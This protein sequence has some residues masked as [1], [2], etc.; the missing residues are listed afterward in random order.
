MQQRHGT[1]VPTPTVSSQSSRSRD[2]DTRGPELLQT[3]PAPHIC[4]QKCFVSSYLPGFLFQ[5][6]SWAN[7]GF[8]NTVF[9]LWAMWSAIAATSLGE[10][11]L[12][13]IF[14]ISGEST[15]FSTFIS[16]GYC[17]FLDCCSFFFNTLLFFHLHLLIFLSL[18]MKEKWLTVGRFVV[19]S[20][21]NCVRQC[22]KK[23]IFWLRGKHEA[24]GSALFCQGIYCGVWLKSL[25]SVDRDV[26][27]AQTTLSLVTGTYCKCTR[28]LFKK[29]LSFF[30]LIPIILGIEEQLLCSCAQPLSYYSFFCF[31]SKTAFF[32]ILKKFYVSFLLL[33]F[34]KLSFVLF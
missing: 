2:I 5:G 30:V 12:H 33:P 22:L 3:R 19:S 34:S 13:L 17:C 8:S 14:F 11:L 29:W 9:P 4:H 16:R 15:G 6:E 20:P 21:Y 26:M 31:S 25:I 27:S 23:G 10:R 24:V 1:A 18:L 28:I 7:Q 32:L